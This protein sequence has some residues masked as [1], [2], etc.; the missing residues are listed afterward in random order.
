MLGAVPGPTIKEAD[1]R[2]YLLRA[3][4]RFMDAVDRWS[5]IFA[6]AAIML[7]VIFILLPAFYTCSQQDRHGSG[8]VSD[9]VKA[10]HKYHGIWVSY[11]DSSG[12]YFIRKGRRCPL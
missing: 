9:R 12:E 2:T 1:M 3:T 5:R 11:Q 10:L 8:V 7:A 6:Y 4:D